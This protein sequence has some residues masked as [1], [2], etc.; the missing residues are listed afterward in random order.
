MRRPIVQVVQELAP[1]GGIQIMVLELERWLSPTL[2]VHVVS[3]E[4]TVERLC[5]TWPRLASLGDRLHG[6]DKPPRVDRGTVLRLKRLLGE[7]CPIAVHTHHIGPLL[8]GGLAA[9]LAG[10]PRLVHTEHDAW[11]LRSPRRRRL[12]RA[13]LAILRPCLVADAQVVADELL[14]AVPSSRPRIVPNGIDTACFAPGDQRTARQMLGL[15]DVACLIGTAGRLEEVKGQD[16]LIAALAELPYDVTLAIAGDGSC[17]ASLE[18]QAA[19]LG[20]GER[21][22]FLG[23][24]ENVAT[25]Y[26]ALD[27]F[28]LPSRAEGLPLSLLEAQACGVPAVVSDVGAVRE[29]MAPDA[30][31]AVAPGDSTQLADGIRQMLARTARADPRP[32][33]VERYDVRS[34]ASAYSALLTA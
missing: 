5:A 17:R 12:E 6:L 31:C 27:L 29:V 23:H 2:D 11:H 33:V 7:I 25:F 21:V 34:M 20:V 15:P 1:P 8:Y 19:R 28:C 16:V 10:V 22:H 24:I 26:Q 14:R 30:S 9:R 18:E 32:F 4:G 13:A 3:L